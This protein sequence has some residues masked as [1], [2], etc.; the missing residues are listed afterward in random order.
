MLYGI[1]I[2]VLKCGCESQNELASEVP[3]PS[4][5]ILFLLRVPFSLLNLL[6]SADWVLPPSVISRGPPV[7]TGGPSTHLS[8]LQ[9]KLRQERA[10]SPCPLA[11]KR[12]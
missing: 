2:P 10:L 4:G 9:Q 6:Q 3:L 12:P 1:I 8:I 5:L 11:I 7:L